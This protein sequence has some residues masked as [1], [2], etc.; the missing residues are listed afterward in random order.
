MNEIQILA[1]FFF[2]IIIAVREYSHYMEIKQL[3]STIDTLTDKVMAKDLVEYKELTQPVK[4]YEPVDHS[5]EA[6]WLR[7]QEER[8]R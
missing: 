6:E 1:L 4:T 7:E 3:H 8:K 5:E 2:V